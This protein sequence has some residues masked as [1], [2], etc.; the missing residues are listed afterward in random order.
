MRAFVAIDLPPLEA[1]IPPG[2]RPEDHLTLHF[3]EELPPERI[4]P[5][6]E[7]MAEAAGGVGPFDLEV[8]GVGAFPAAGRP[9][10]VWAGVT[11]GSTTVRSLVDRLRRALSERGFAVEARPF[12]P[13]LTLARVRSPR[14]VTWA[15]QFLASPENGSR[16][17]TRTRATELLLK[18][19]ELLPTGAR[20][21][22]REREALRGPSPPPPPAPGPP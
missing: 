18:E 4:P 8:R 13:H 16:V 20:H 7:A 5:A 21:M 2:L 15:R 22:V 11:E 17:W 19:S 6:V 12:I 10:V 14:D 1:P 9:R 3:F